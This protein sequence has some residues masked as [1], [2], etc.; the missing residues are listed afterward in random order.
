[1]TSFDPSPLEEAEPNIGSATKDMLYKKGAAPKVGSASPV[2]F[3]RLIFHVVPA[4]EARAEDAAVKFKQAQDA[5]SAKPSGGNKKK[6]EKAWARIVKAKSQLD[7]VAK[8]LEMMA[9]YA[10]DHGLI[11]AS[12]E[13]KK[14]IQALIGKSVKVVGTASSVGAALASAVGMPSADSHLGSLSS[15]LTDLVKSDPGFNDL[16]AVKADFKKDKN[17]DPNYKKPESNWQKVLGVKGPAPKASPPPK[18]E[19]KTEPAPKKKPEPKKKEPP[20]KDAGAATASGA[21]GAPSDAPAT[22]PGEEEPKPK[23][24]KKDFTPSEVAEIKEASIKAMKAYAA[25]STSLA[26]KSDDIAALIQEDFS[27][28]L[29]N[30][31]VKKLIDA[32]YKEITPLSIFGAE[33]AFMNSEIKKVYDDAGTIDGSNYKDVAIKC[34]LGTG[35][36]PSVEDYMDVTLDFL[37]KKQAE[38][39]TL[40]Q[41]SAEDKKAAISSFKSVYFSGIVVSP[42]TDDFIPAF[43]PDV[44][45]NVKAALNKAGWN[46][47]D[48]SVSALMKQGAEAWEGVYDDL[49]K[50]QKKVVLD[51]AKSALKDQKKSTGSY[52]G[53][54]GKVMS[55]VLGLNLKTFIGKEMD[56]IHSLAIS[57]LKDEDSKPDVEGAV[58]KVKD[59]LEDVDQEPIM[60]NLGWIKNHL[61]ETV[62]GI[63][64]VSFL[65]KYNIKNDVD[66]PNYKSWA[67]KVQWAAS[68]ELK[69]KFDGSSLKKHLFKTWTQFYESEGFD[70]YAHN[71]M[72]LV[73]GAAHFDLYGKNYGVFEKNIYAA[74][75]YTK[76]S[77]LNMVFNDWKFEEHPKLKKPTP[78]PAAVAAPPAPTPVTNT[79]PVAPAPAA[80]AKPKTGYVESELS[81]EMKA[82]LAGYIEADAMP[83]L[84][85]STIIGRVRKKFKK[86]YGYSVNIKHVRALVQAALKDKAA[87][88]P[89]DFSKKTEQILGMTEAELND[90][91]KLTKPKSSPDKPE[92]F[93]YSKNEGSAV[94]KDA[95]GNPIKAGLGAHAKSWADGPTP[96]QAWMFKPTD[97]FVAAAEVVA[98]RAMQLFGVGVTKHVW[99]DN[100]NGS[101]GSVQLFEAGNTLRKTGQEHNAWNKGFSRELQ[102]L[103]IANWL[104]GDHDDHGDNFIIRGDGQLE[105]I[106]KGQA[107]KFF[108]STGY[109]KTPSGKTHALSSMWSPPSNAGFQ[110]KSLSV[111]MLREWER[112]GDID[113]N[114]MDSGF[115]SVIDRAEAIPSSVYK[116]MWRPYAEAAKKKGLLA[117]FSNN[118]A[119]KT[120]DGF[121][122]NIDKRRR[123]LRADVI[124]M[125]KVSVDRRAKALGKSYDEVAEEVGLTALE[126]TVF[127]EIGSGEIMGQAFSTA[128][129]KAKKTKD[130]ADIQAA[131][132]LVSGQLTKI[133]GK[134]TKTKWDNLRIAALEKYVQDLDEEFGKDIP[135]TSK[136]PTMEKLKKRGFLGAQMMV[137]SGTGLNDV[138][139]GKMSVWRMG[140]A[141]F[142]SL[143]LSKAARSKIE[144]VLAP[145]VAGGAASKPVGPEQTRA[146]KYRE[147][148]L[149][150]AA[151]DRIQAYV[152]HDA[153]SSLTPIR[154][155]RGN[156]EKWVKGESV[157]ASVLNKDKAE[158]IEA[159]K[160]Y[161]AYITKIMNDV[162]NSDSAYV[163]YGGVKW[164]MDLSLPKAD[165]VLEKDFE[166]KAEV[167]E[168]KKEKEDEKNKKA[169]PPPP[170]KFRK[171]NFIPWFDG[172]AEGVKNATGELQ[173]KSSGKRYAHESYSYNGSPYGDKT[174]APPGAYDFDGK[175]AFGGTAY[176]IDLG[177]GVIAVYQPDMN[178]KRSKRGVLKIKFGDKTKDGDI[179]KGLAKLKELGIAVQP[180]TR[181]E[182]EASYLRKMAWMWRRAGSGENEDLHE[183]EPDGL[184][185]AETIA[186]YKDKLTKAPATATSGFNVGG[187]QLVMD[188][189][190]LSSSNP[191]Y[192]PIP[193]DFGGVLEWR[194]PDVDEATFKKLDDYILYSGTGSD[195]TTN[196]KVAMSAAMSWEMRSQRGVPIKGASNSADEGTGGSHD[197]YMRIGKRSKIGNNPCDARYSARRLAYTGW[198]YNPS[199]SYGNKFSSMKTSAADVRKRY[200]NVSKLLQSAAKHSVK[201]GAGGGQEIMVD[202]LMSPEHWGDSFNLSATGR[203]AVIDGLK[204]RGINKIAQ[205]GKSVE[206]L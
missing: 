163:K 30:M 194:R 81:D 77:W 21:Q 200:T 147:L 54:K 32:A 116:E 130:V 76:S 44:V 107:A 131:R 177:D 10:A 56:K 50:W 65:A 49:K 53:A 91:I 206:D 139:D 58:A 46:L 89:T 61:I 47:T 195:Q 34:F 48:G 75:G 43:A 111:T 180:A 186:W 178:M 156:L 196:K 41:L 13:K 96:G 176:E 4:A 145:F 95:D 166:F 38:P 143:N 171:F 118:S 106:D 123:E 126:N 182:T 105:P 93:P 135:E 175:V 6:V 84:K 83:G 94:L 129:A 201:C 141:A 7:F 69:A 172:D 164:E 152:D 150:Q 78:A 109:T 67:A 154:I 142:G 137:G 82:S 70:P 198:N 174:S 179:E 25:V 39:K 1:M 181:D 63:D 165:R 170:F 97:E 68:N 188:A 167:A 192:N 199:D 29:D 100:V 33:L 124:A 191:S 14:E 127:G 153:N 59:A 122:E 114:L 189:K 204:K 18:T 36:I 103:Q 9:S 79:V 148:L 8:K 193:E 125:Y 31:A 80:P 162:P 110:E 183:M 17:Y 98:N 113:L 64:P 51:A 20:K 42:S 71:S 60:A 168:K 185:A 19:P 108:T 35:I 133:K 151:R 160:H 85:E 90:F 203:K 62:M 158:F 52:D 37:D 157:P 102:R 159:A 5:Y 87:P 144:S 149:P 27:E 132:N 55:K 146:N 104:I 88:A 202:G 121:L 86:K 74:A 190:T 99:M 11:N 169:P 12:D 161:H 140:D 134:A 155:A 26:F 3:K 28:P 119:D 187:G 16:D 184:T 92:V 23:A 197:V 120:V 57:E 115:L 45:A 205:T 112:G 173:I 138:R 73:E 22:S 136:P 24:P 101:M 128:F 117:K 72:Y 40:G 2:E 66:D 15:A